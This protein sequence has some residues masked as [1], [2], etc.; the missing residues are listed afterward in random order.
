MT[1]TTSRR[2]RRQ[3]D[4]NTTP[5]RRPRHDDSH[6]DSNTRRGRDGKDHHR[7][8]KRLEH[9]L[10]RRLHNSDHDN[11]NDNDM[12]TTT[13]TT[14]CGRQF[15]FPSCFSSSSLLT[16]PLPLSFSLCS[17]PSRT[18]SPHHSTH[19]PTLIKHDKWDTGVQRTMFMHVTF[20][21][22]FTPQTSDTGIGSHLCLR[23]YKHTI[24]CNFKNNYQNKNF[25]VINF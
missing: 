19:P 16:H 25:F 24:V 9:N 7:T 1:R 18:V 11:D 14:T 10:K 4:E 20:H 21:D 5:T 22:G 15:Y 8:T 6:H 23:P 12:S 2:P 13:Q 17:N 3:Q